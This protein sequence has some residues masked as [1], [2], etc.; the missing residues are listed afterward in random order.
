METIV[1]ILV[2]LAVLMLLYGQLMRGLR[3]QPITVQPLPENWRLV[4]DR[5]VVFYKKLDEAG[6]QRF[7][8]RMMHFLATTRLTGVKTDVSEE[9]KVYIAASAI[10]PIFGFDGWEYTNLREVLLYP[11]SFNHDFEQTGNDRSILGMVGDGALNNTMVL[12]RHE[13]QQAFLNKSSKTNT[14]IHEFVHLVDKTDGAI[15]GIPEFFMDK[16]FVLPWLQLIEDS[17]NNIM[18]N[19]SDINPYGATN[20]AEF[21]AVVSEY[22]FERPDLLKSKH[23]ELYDLLVKMFNQNPSKPASTSQ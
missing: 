11:D 6:K 21:L 23:P 22:F 13:L 1:I 18:R 7:E 17:I 14:A 16:K 5:D 12:S 10:I 2:V 19:K 8:Y 9:D 20:H 15:D 4:L 3:K